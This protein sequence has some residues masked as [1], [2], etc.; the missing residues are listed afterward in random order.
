MFER[1]KSTSHEVLKTVIE[2]CSICINHRRALL[3]PLLSFGT[4]ARMMNCFRFHPFFFFSSRQRYYVFLSSNLPASWDLFFV[5]F[6]SGNFSSSSPVLCHHLWPL[7]E[8][9]VKLLSHES[10][11]SA[12]KCVSFIERLSLPFHYCH[13]HFVSPLQKK[14]TSLSRCSWWL[15]CTIDVM[16]TSSRCMT[17]CHEWNYT[18]RK[19]S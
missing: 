18:R 6:I 15:Y 10:R 13:C 4:R 12:G 5:S 9:S 2:Q 11:F 8:A 3:R 14:W 17:A 19:Q 16:R 1:K 7:F